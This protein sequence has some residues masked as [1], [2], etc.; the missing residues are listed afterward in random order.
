M[1]GLQDLSTLAYW[2]KGSGVVLCKSWDIGQSDHGPR[3]LVQ[4]MEWHCLYRMAS[5]DKYETYDRN[6]HLP[7]RKL[8]RPCQERSA[9]HASAATTRLR[10]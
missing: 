2:S 7:L 5:C 4:S 1:S 8:S 3:L 10:T 6:E 9:D